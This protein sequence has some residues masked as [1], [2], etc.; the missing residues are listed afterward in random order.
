MVI[1]AVL[2][3][4]G[5]GWAAWAHYHHRAVKNTL[6]ESKSNDQAPAAVNPAVQPSYDID[7]PTSLTVIINKQRALPTGYVPANLVVPKVAL[8]LNSSAEQMH[9][10]LEASIAL[11]KMFAAAKLDGISMILSSGYRSAVYQQQLYSGYVSKNGQAEADKSSARP[12]HSEHQ[13]G[14]AADIGEVD[15][16]CDLEACFADTPSGR[17]LAA[18]AQE[19]GFIIRYQANTTAITGYEYEPWHVRYLGIELATAV[20]NSGKTLE[21]YFNLPPAPD[22]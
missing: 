12:N 5:G 6:G 3:I 11:E 16:K 9:L 2:V 8:R 7:T 4:T 1:V 20:K 21:E 17:W 19:Y 10:R 22:Y 18:H 13:T 15:H 14:L